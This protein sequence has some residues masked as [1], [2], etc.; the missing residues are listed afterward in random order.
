ML[1]LARRAFMVS[2]NVPCVPT[3]Y[4]KASRPGRLKVETGVRIAVP[5]QQPQV[6]V[7]QPQVLVVISSAS[8]HL[9][10]ENSVLRIVR[11]VIELR[12]LGC[13]ERK[14]SV[15]DLEIRRLE[16]PLEY[17]DVHA[18]D[19]GDG[20]R[21]TDDLTQIDPFAERQIVGMEET[22]LAAWQDTVA[23]DIEERCLHM[24]ALVVRQHTDVQLQTDGN[25]AR[26]Q[27][28]QVLAHFPERFEVVFDV[29]EQAGRSGLGSQ[30]VNGHVG[31]IPTAGP[32][33]VG[34]GALD[35]RVA[36]GDGIVIRG[37][38]G[39]FDGLAEHVRRVQ[40][41]FRHGFRVRAAFRG[42]RIPHGNGCTADRIRQNQ[43]RNRL[44]SDVPRRAVADAVGRLERHTAG[45]LHA[46]RPISEAQ[47]RDAIVVDL[48]HEIPVGR[49]ALDQV[50]EHLPPLGRLGRQPHLRPR[51]AHI[52]AQQGSGGNPLVTGR[53]VG[54]QRLP[55][56][57]RRLLQ[58]GADTARDDLNVAGFS[59]AFA[60]GAGGERGDGAEI[61]GWLGL[62][63]IDQNDVAAR[64]ADV[65]EIQA[66]RS[67]T[68]GGE[69]EREG[70]RVRGSPL[71]F[72]I[73][74]GPAVRIKEYRVFAR[75]DFGEAYGLAAQRIGIRS[76]S[77]LGA[78]HFLEDEYVAGEQLEFAVLLAG[79]AVQ[80]G[81]RSAA[82][83]EAT[84]LLAP[85][86]ERNPAVGGEGL[87]GSAL[88]W[89]KDFVAGGGNLIQI[90]PGQYGPRLRE[91]V[92]DAGNEG[93]PGG[94][95]QIRVSF[96]TYPCAGI[97][98][99][100]Q[101]IVHQP[102]QAPHRDALAG[103]FQIGLGGNRVLVV[104]EVVA[105]VG[106]PLN[107][108]DAEIGGVGFLPVRH[109]DGE[110]VQNELPETAVVFREVIDL[111]LRHHR[112]W[113]GT[114]WGAIQI[115][116]AVDFEREVGRLIVRV[117]VSDTD[118]LQR[119][120]GE[121]TGLIDRDH[122]RIVLIGTWIDDGRQTGDL[123]TRD[124]PPARDRQVRYGLRRI[125]LQF[126]R[127]LAEELR[128]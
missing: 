110:A 90:G 68:D 118:E 55:V 104:T 117:D 66:F 70:K 107:Q 88:D 9:Q 39:A 73:R 74:R 112:R 60:G 101:E 50:V 34:G 3:R 86:V 62:A 93:R 27:N 16:Q 20:L 5:S 105:G 128:S 52:L 116:R 28:L 75:S 87:D 23:E 76:Q 51:L 36:L 58:G 8:Q 24:A 57:E 67:G 77:G 11:V 48:D 18:L 69:T 123:N 59:G 95:R 12:Y 1:M 30:R 71:D 15:F 25:I 109:E 91:G 17:A 92:I 102:H 78:D 114:G 26:G 80:Q 29:L 22:F 106:E 79:P 40:L 119:I 10:H 115:G 4:C 108:R 7:V 63:I 33:Q 83:R 126:G 122:Q 65:F 13:R 82:S 47:V 64:D 41:G 44:G 89:L 100:V 56:S 85:G 19:A 2:K 35:L 72:E 14:N 53:I 6:C 99:F 121:I 54:G 103:G 49:L 84:F 96:H 45:R 97:A 46:Q 31:F 125:V 38:D 113:T 32:V 98:A 94:Q 21:N 124:P 111:G 61:L 81:R 127:Q 37:S 120:S 43:A 42:Q